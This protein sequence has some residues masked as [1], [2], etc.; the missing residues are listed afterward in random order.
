MSTAGIPHFVHLQIRR[1]DRLLTEATRYRNALGRL[2][3]ARHR[4]RIAAVS[5]DI[6]SL[7][8]ELAALRYAARHPEV[9]A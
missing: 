6:E 1:L 8:S 7:K 2:G 9:R 4:V 5:A 3:S